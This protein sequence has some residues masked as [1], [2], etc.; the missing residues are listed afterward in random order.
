VN[1][2]GAW[3]PN[4]GTW[5]DEWHTLSDLLELPELKECTTT[6]WEKTDCFFGGSYEIPEEQ[7]LTVDRPYVRID[8]VKLQELLRSRYRAANGVTVPSKL[9]A[10]LT[11]PNLFDKGLTH[12]AKGSVLTLDDGSV[13]KC[14][15][16]I[17]ASGSESRLVGK[18]S[19]TTA[20]GS[21]K[22]LPTGYQIAYGFT[23]VVDTLG[24]YDV[25][26]MTLFDYR[27]DHLTGAWLADGI[28]KPTF[29]YAMPLASNPADGTHKM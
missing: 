17:D 10:T 13:V 7:R 24:P 18:E 12:H 9:S 3:Y 8:R 2:P 21:D 6:E 29:M 23:A 1:T 27:T 14:K 22:E 5:R 15:V 16:V 4:Y 25:E 20:R 28:R 19:S 26:A 11:S